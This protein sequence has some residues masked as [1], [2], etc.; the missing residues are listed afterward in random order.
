[1]LDLAGGTTVYP[2][3]KLQ[4]SGGCHKTKISTRPILAL[5]VY[6]L[7]PQAH[8]HKDSEVGRIRILDPYET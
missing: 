4:W 6:I 3:E 2:Q 1:M 7:Q 8:P 5:H